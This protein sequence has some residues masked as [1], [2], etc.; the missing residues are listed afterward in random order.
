[1]TVEDER[2]LAGLKRSGA[3]VR[4]ILRTML[5]EAKAGVTGLELDRMAQEMM[6]RAGARSAPR[7]AYNFPGATCISI[8][9]V[10][11]H[12]IPDER[13]L[14]EGDLINIDVSLDLDGYWTDSGASMV[15]GGKATPEQA[16][17][18][19]TTRRAMTKGIYGA[20]AGQPINEIGRRV[21]AEAKAGGF[22]VCNT[23]TGHGV[24]RSIHEEPTV[25]NHYVRSAR[26]K[27]QEG[28]VITVEPFLTTGNAKI[29]EAD[30]G[31]SLYPA[32]MAP[33]AQFEHTI[34]VT[35]GAPI[36]LTA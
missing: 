18:L 26:Q 3:L 23:L 15:V 20:K 17:L 8:E 2:Q 19:E 5:N 4:D 1:M 32:D 29:V 27:L 28:L 35:R 34:V 30:D 21:E 9:G 11:A 16:K 22:K 31:W 10:V 13:P 36:I 12:G 24:G 6:D 25:W 33:M 14:R 7:A